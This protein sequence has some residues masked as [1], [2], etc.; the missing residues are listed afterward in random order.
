[1]KPRASG[2]SLLE[3]LIAIGLV[4]FALL[5]LMGVYISNLKLVDQSSHISDATEVGREMLERIK[6]VE[7]ADLPPAPSLFDGGAGMPQVGGFPPEP[8]PVKTINGVDYAIEI[9]L[10]PEGNL[11]SVT[12]KVSWSDSTITLQTYLREDDTLE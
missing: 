1:M 9:L 8:Y 12:A 7:Y 6:E 4:A 5:T 3:I 2:L 10:Q 11:V